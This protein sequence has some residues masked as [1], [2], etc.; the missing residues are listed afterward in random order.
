MS[1]RDLSTDAK[2]VGGLALLLFALVA[3]LNPARKG[4]VRPPVSPTTLATAIEQGTDHVTADELARML[5]DKEP[6][7]AVVDIREPADYA[8]FHIK[9]S[10]NIPLPLLFTKKGTKQLRD[11]STVVLV[12]T[13]GTHAAQAWTVLRELGVDHVVTLLGGLNYWVD[14]FTN[15]HPPAETAADPEIATAELR[16]AAGA[17]FFGA[18]KVEEAPK[19]TAPR[20]PVPI[21][22]RRHKGKGD[23]GC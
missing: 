10:I 23:E 18:P 3:L 6:G 19:A 1:V 16:R 7:L 14:V 22:K 15:P 9:G 11:M 17:H 4:P 2:V 13:G 8:D 20:P 21:K 12:S 5:I